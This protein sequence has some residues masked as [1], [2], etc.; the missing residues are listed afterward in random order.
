M[1]TTENKGLSGSAA[2]AGSASARDSGSE[3]SKQ[4]FDDQEQLARLG[5]KSVLKVEHYKRPRNRMLLHL[6]TFN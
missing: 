2:E 6:T 3:L 5:K 1:A 4:D